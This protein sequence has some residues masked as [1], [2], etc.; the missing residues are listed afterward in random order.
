[1]DF[2][3]FPWHFAKS[4]K[5]EMQVPKL[6]ASRARLR[7]GYPTEVCAPLPRE[8]VVPAPAPAVL[9]GAD[10]AREAADPEAVLQGRR[11]PLHLDSTE[12]WRNDVRRRASYL[13]RS[14]VPYAVQTS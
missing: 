2:H 9:R 6:C 1:M 8:L 11:N 12:S 10:A 13:K 3:D 5:F 4:G 14:K 7:S